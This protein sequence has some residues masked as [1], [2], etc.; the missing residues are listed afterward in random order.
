MKTL[1]YLGFGQ[2]HKTSIILHRK[3]DNQNKIAVKNKKEAN[4]LR[5]MFPTLSVAFLKKLISY[6]KETGLRYSKVHH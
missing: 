2:N 6:S 4:I 1:T 3:G 5:S